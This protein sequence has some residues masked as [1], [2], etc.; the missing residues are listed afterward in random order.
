AAGSL[1]YPLA[2]KYV[3]AKTGRQTLY[4]H[5]L[6]RS[7]LVYS[8]TQCDTRFT[9]VVY[10]GRP[11]E[12]HLAIFPRVPGGLTTPHTP[13]NVSYYLDQAQRARSVTAYSAA[14]CM[15]RAA[16][17]QLMFDKGFTRGMLDAKIKELEGQISGGNPPSWARDL[18]TEYLRVM[19][20]LGNAAIHPNG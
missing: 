3:R 18:D 14:I 17:E 1:S 4:A 8:C 11:G 16:L 2:P 10:E 20:E 7:L 6:A 5:E 19:K 15:Y 12:P 9:A 13:A